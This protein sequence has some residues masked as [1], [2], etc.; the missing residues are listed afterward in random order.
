MLIV[1]DGARPLR[2]HRRRRRARARARRH[3]HRLRRQ[4]RARRR[5]RALRP[6]PRR[7]GDRPPGD[8][9]R[10]RDLRLHQ[11][12]RHGGKPRCRGEIGFRPVDRRPTIRCCAAGSHAPHVREWWGDPEEELGFI[13]DMVEGRDTTRPFVIE[14]D[15]A[16]VGYIQVWFIGHHQNATWIDDHPWLAELPVGRG[17]RRPLARRPRAAVAG[18]RLGR[19]RRLRRAG[20][21]P[22]AT[23]TI[24]ID[25]DPANARAVRAYAKAGFRP[26]PH[27]EGRTGDMLIMQYHPN[28]QTARHDRPDP[29]RDRL[30]ARPLH[31]RPGRRQ[32]RRRRGAAQPLAAQ[33]AAGRHPRGGLPEEHPDDRPDRRRQDR[34]LAPPRQARQGAVPQGRGDQVHRGRLRRPRRRADRPRPRRRRDR[35][36]P[37]G[38]CASGSRPAPTRPPRTGCIDALAGEGARDQTREMFRRKLRVRRARRQGDRARGRRH[39]EPVPDDGDPRPA[40]HGHGRAQPRRHLR[41]GLR[42]PP[43]SAAG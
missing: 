19:A 39:L 33:A 8:G 3:R 14:L 28:A 38:R 25:P 6:G 1:T 27:L 7:R 2:H 21:A 43:R 34:D 15:G 10:R 24:V 16:P 40:R 30:R 12:Q 11:R 29:P 5:P 20:C 17:R 13:R 41:Q 36:D 23:A 42:R 26:I 35:H 22:R 18:H 9:D 31:H 4:L 37:R 32:A